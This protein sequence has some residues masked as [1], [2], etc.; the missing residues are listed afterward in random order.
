MFD[1]PGSGD[2]A[3]EPWVQF[4][5]LDGKQPV[6]CRNL[7]E[8]VEWAMREARDQLPHVGFTEVGHAWVSTIFLPTPSGGFFNEPRRFFETAVFV[9]G[10]DDPLLRRLGRQYATWDEA[11]AGHQEIVELLRR[12]QK[13]NTGE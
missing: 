9:T 1:Q 3:G 13:K 2:C 7:A 5:R 6:P 11:E 4:Y 12:L 8:W 10:G